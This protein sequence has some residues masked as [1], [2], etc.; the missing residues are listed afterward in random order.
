MPDVDGASPLALSLDSG[1]AM[2]SSLQQRVECVLMLDG[3]AFDWAR[4][5]WSRL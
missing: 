3:W 1:G 4:L 5:W 2:V